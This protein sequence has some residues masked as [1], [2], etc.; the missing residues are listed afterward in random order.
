ME[1]RELIHYWLE[2]AGRDME[3][4]EKLYKMEEYP[5][6]LFLGQLVLEKTL[7]A[8]L[9]RMW[10]WRYQESMTLSGLPFLLGSKYLRLRLNPW[11]SSA[12]ST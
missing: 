6:A 11:M 2:S 4:M 3:T 9:P 1:P 10:V 5:W 8:V 12:A 7:K